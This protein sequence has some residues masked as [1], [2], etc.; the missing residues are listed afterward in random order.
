[1]ERTSASRKEYKQK[2]RDKISAYMKDYRNANRESIYET[3][4][5]YNKNHP[6]AI[7]AIK[8]KTYA[9]HRDKHLEQHKEY[10]QE[11]LTER[12]QYNQN[13]YQRFRDKIRDMVKS[14]QKAHPEI[15]TKNRLRRDFHIQ[16]NG[17]NFSAE[18]WFD[19]CDKYD[20]ICLCC[21]QSKPLTVDHIIPL[22]K[23][24]TNDISNI[25]P[26]CISCNSK[27]KT[28]TIDYRW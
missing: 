25:Q 11:H 7:K 14:Y 18:E 23:G 5:A 22:S 4:K 17:G 13:Y 1:M 28:K 6:D 10:Y 8:K 15:S 2:N 16:E 21:R 3:Q 9:K 20:N 27:K 24:G 19:L 12:T 26:L